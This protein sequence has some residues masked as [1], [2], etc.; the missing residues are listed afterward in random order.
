[1]RVVVT[2]KHIKEGLRKS[3]CYCPVAWALKDAFG[4]DCDPR[5]DVFGLAMVTMG[6]R[7]K[8]PCIVLQFIDRFDSGGAV[9]PFEFELGPAIK[10]FTR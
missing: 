9:R 6:V 8:T 10:S 1:M 7:Y 5:V 3:R 2:E 4:L